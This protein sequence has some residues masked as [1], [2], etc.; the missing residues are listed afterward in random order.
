[1]DGPRT[2]RGSFCV[3]LV[4]VFGDPSKRVS[5]F[6]ARPSLIMSCL[7]RLVSKQQAG[8]LGVGMAVVTLG[9]VWSF[10]VGEMLA[11]LCRWFPL[12]VQAVGPGVAW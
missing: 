6:C 11:P 4:A 2:C 9:T 5:G 3:L 8:L 1:M 7:E 12:P 10:R